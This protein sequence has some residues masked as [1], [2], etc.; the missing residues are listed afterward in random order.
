MSDPSLLNLSELA[1]AYRRGDLRP[2]E[3][4]EHYLQKLEPGSIYRCVTAERAQ[5]QA[6]AADALFE[7]G[8]DLGPLQG[9]PL[10]IKDLI[11][12]KGE[13]SSAGSR[14]LASKPAAREDAPVLARLDT[15]GAVFLGRTTMTELA[16]S[17]LGLNPHYGTPAN[18]LDASRIPGGSSSGSAVAVAK[19]LAC[20]AL[21]SDTGGSVRI[22]A[23]FNGLI[24]L[25]TTNG[26]IPN[27]GVTPLSTTLDTL[28]PITRNLED[29]W[30]LWHAMTAKLS[31]AF[32]VPDNR[33]FRLLAPETVILNDADPEVIQTYQQCLHSFEAAGHQIIHQPVP[34]FERILELYAKHGSFA[35]HESLAL[36]QELLES[37]GP[38][39][40]HRVARRILEYR[41]R[42]ATDYLRLVYEQKSMTR[43]FWERTREFDAILCPTVAILPPKISDLASDSAYFS[44]NGLVLRNTMLFNFLTGPALSIPCALTEGGLSIGLMIASAPYS[45]EHCFKVATGLKSC[46]GSS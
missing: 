24:G 42:P 36:Y 12:M 39:I 14:V 11:D 22:P 46:L 33:T 20:A 9:I 7:R 17:G 23:S 30:H 37:H 25:K 21:G 45:E 34:E 40:D 44:S 26:S 5:A 8:I 43:S 41:G 18:A 27:D 16:F 32:P 10:A 38:A 28:G 1:H 2:S 6:R 4:T 15:L 35:S 13:V 31:K 29:A 19:Q 3:V